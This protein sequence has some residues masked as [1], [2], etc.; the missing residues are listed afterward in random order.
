MRLFSRQSAILLWIAGLCWL[1]GVM[2]YPVS[3]GLTRAM[4]VA[5]SAVLIVGLLLLWWRYRVLRWTL[6]GLCIAVALFSALPGRAD[7]DR[8]A[9]RQE[10]VHALQRY[11]G[12]RY[13]GGGENFLGI[14]CSGLV[15]RGTI[16]GTFVYGIRTLNPLLVREAALLWWRDMSARDMA[17]GAGRKARKVAEEKSI[18]TLNDKI[19]HPGDFAITSNGIHAL[20][21]LGDHVW[22][23]ADPGERKVIRFDARTAKNNWVRTPISVLRWRLLDLPQRTAKTPSAIN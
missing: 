9:L 10:V 14:D 6:L 4:G 5:L 21:Y 12:V 22:L 16:E 23:E 20:A 17:L 13:V 1:L 3:I 15:R 7:Y 18:A 19:V 8:P 11:E 2:L